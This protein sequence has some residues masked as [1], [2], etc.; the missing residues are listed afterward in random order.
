MLLSPD[1]CYLV[2]GCVSSNLTI[3]NLTIWAPGDSPNTDGV[4]TG[5]YL[6]YQKDIERPQVLA[7]WRYNIFYLVYLILSFLLAQSEESRILSLLWLIL[8]SHLLQSSYGALI[9]DRTVMLSCLYTQTIGL[10]D[11]DD[12]NVRDRFL[13]ECL[14]RGLQYQH[15]W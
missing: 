15:R 10:S 9:S 6:G 8:G 11:S 1:T 5:M 7:S 14:Y 13:H 12:Q 4:V 2:I 3:R